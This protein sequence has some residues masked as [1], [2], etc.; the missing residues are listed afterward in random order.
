MSTFKV[1]LLYYA[2]F[3]TILLVTGATESPSTL[4]TVT[5]SL[6]SEFPEFYKHTRKFHAYQVP[7]FVHEVNAIVRKL[8]HIQKQI[9]L[10]YFYKVTGNY[11]GYTHLKKH[12]AILSAS[13]QARIA[14]LESR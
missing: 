6:E 14:R 12:V 4:S 10:L 3:S 2:V 1:C 8:I 5:R 7:I 9:G 13:A 11:H